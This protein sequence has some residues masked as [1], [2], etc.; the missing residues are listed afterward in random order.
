ATLVGSHS[1]SELEKASA[2]RSFDLTPPTD[3]RPFFFNQVPF[4]KPLSALSIAHQRLASG[5]QLGGVRDGNF[6]ATAT[7]LILFLVS[8]ILVLATIVIPLRPAIRDVGR[9]LTIGGTLYFLFIGLGFM[10][11]EIALLQRTSVFLG[12]PVYSL[13]VLLFT[14]ILST[15][16]GSL[17]SDIFE[18]K[19]R[20][21][22]VTW[23]LVTSS[24][25]IVLPL[26]FANVFP[27]FD[28]SPLLGRAALCVATIA[29]LGV[30]LGFAFPTGMRL[31]N[32]V[33][34]KP[35]PWFWGVNGAAGVL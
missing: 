31:I 28:G 7:L 17:L 35:A 11:V 32:S 10:L 24:Y 1:R 15:G 9:R 30:L 19:N 26:S 3:D 4:N 16:T 22:F 33:D 23:S 29:P 12:H 8:L 25:I 20:K 2:G 6:V 5:D 14:L 27:Q 18:L 13:S 21:R 34:R